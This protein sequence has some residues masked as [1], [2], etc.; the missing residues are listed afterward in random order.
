MPSAEDVLSKLKSTALTEIIEAKAKEQCQVDVKTP[1]AVTDFHILLRAYLLSSGRTWLIRIPKDQEYSILGWA[2]V[3]PLE[4]VA[5]K[6]PNLPAPRAHGHSDS[7]DLA[8]NPVGVC[9]MMLDWIHGGIVPP[10]TLQSPSLEAKRLVLDQL[11][12]LMLDMLLAPAT[13]DILYGRLK[14][15]FVR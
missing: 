11:A 9:Y 13:G 15:R 7:S 14:S 3:R 4:Y 2:S 6:F 5:E 12:E 10:F 8:N 1:V